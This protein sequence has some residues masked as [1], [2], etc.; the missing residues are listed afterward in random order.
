M[1]SMPDMRQRMRCAKTPAERQALM[2]GPM[3]AMHDGMAMMKEIH[4][5]MQGMGGM[6]MGD[7]TGKG[8][9]A[10]MAKRHQ[11]VTDHMPSMQM[12]MDMMSDRMA[13]ASV[14]K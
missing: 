13:P 8:M 1:K 3:K 2:A 6:G 9:P 4:G 12:M 11:M 14:M 7:E 10:D 5:G